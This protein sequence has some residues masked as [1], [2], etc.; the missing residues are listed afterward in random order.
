[1]AL[2][3]EARV[4]CAK[5]VRETD[6]MAPV[7]ISLVALLRKGKLS[8]LHIWVHMGIL[9][10]LIL[11]TSMEHLAEWET[12]RSVKDINFMWFGN[13]LFSITTL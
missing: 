4:P 9:E 7:L 6:A 11:M 8:T 5:S 1:M 2:P 12:K 3:G 13:L 10:N